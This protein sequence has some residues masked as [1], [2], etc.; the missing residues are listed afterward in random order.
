MLAACL[1]RPRGPLRTR[2]TGRWALE[3]IGTPSPR[4][5]GYPRCHG[6]VAWSLYV[7]AHFSLSPPRYCDFWYAA[8]IALDST[9]LKPP[10]SNW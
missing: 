9:V 5:G 10:F 2:Q 7:L 6:P 1:D 8:Q 4:T 3:P